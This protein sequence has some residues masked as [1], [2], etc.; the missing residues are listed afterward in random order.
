MFK[1]IISLVLALMVLVSM[2]AMATSVSAADNKIYFEVPSDWQNFK[3]VFCHIWVYN[4]DSLASWQSKKEKCVDEGNGIYSYDLSKVGGLEAGQYYGV[5]FSLDIGAQTYDTIMTSACIGDTLYCNDTIYE[6]PQ[7]SSKTARAAFWK[8]QDPA[9]YGPVMQITSIGNLIGTCLP[10]GVTATDLFNTFLV[11]WL[12]SAR[13][14]SGKSGDQEIIDDMATALGLSQAQVKELIDASELTIDWKMEE[15]KAPEKEQAIKP[16][17]GGAVSSG[18]EMT[19]VFIALATMIAAAGV[20]L[21][22]RKK[23]NG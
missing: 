11:D 23:V 22:A 21:V 16:G 20:I 9:Q 4:G 1:K 3:S 6:N 14:Y 2:A 8:N 10:P 18:Q 13:T 19:V 12:D 5:I 17:N 7:D 15:S